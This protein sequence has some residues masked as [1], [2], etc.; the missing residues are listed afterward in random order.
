MHP[1]RAR[2]HAPAIEDALEVADNVA[3]LRAAVGPAS[4]PL[5]STTFA[6]CARPRRPAQRAEECRYTTESPRRATE[7][8]HTGRYPGAGYR[9][10][11]NSSS[12]SSEKEQDEQ[13]D[14]DHDDDSAADV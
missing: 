2:L 4:P 9:F 1:P 3:R 12:R 8:S 7:G 14:Q 13:D 11:P 6:S 10:R 5:Q